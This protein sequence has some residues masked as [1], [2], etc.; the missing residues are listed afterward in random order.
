MF[1]TA[2]ALNFN[3]DAPL[4][5]SLTKQPTSLAVQGQVYGADG[6]C[7]VHRETW[8]SD[9]GNITLQFSPC[10]AASPF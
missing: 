7:T 9:K 6:G 10:L 3:Y 8:K 4:K 5:G 2:S 1:S